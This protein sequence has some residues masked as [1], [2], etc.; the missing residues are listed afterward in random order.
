MRSVQNPCSQEMLPYTHNHFG[1]EILFEEVG[2]ELDHISV[3]D[4]AVEIF[5]T[6]KYG[7]CYSTV[8]HR[9]CGEIVELEFD[10]IEAL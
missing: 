10:E 1:I 7:N 4:Q 9:S 2:A 8:G 6:D 5:G 3:Y